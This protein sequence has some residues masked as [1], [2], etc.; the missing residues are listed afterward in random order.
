MLERS[1]QDFLDARDLDDL[2]VDFD[3]SEEVEIVDLDEGEMTRLEEGYNP[4][5][6]LLTGGDI[7]ANTEQAATVGDEAVGGTVMTPDQN[8]VEDIGAAVGLE[9]SD[10]EWLHTDEILNLR[11]DRRWELDPKSSEDYEQRR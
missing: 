8:V 7:Y 4:A 9:M 2:D 1:E 11:D 10:K 5:D 3:G 6:A